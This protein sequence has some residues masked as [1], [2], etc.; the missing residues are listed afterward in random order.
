ML[1]ELVSAE[2][3]RRRRQSTRALSLRLWAAGPFAAVLVV[4]ALVTLGQWFSGTITHADLPHYGVMLLYLLGLLLVPARLVLLVSR[5]QE[6]ANGVV[7][8]TS[9]LVLWVVGGYFVLTTPA[10]KVVDWPKQIMAS[11]GETVQ[12]QLDVARAREAERQ[13]EE[14]AQQAAKAKLAD[15]ANDDLADAQKVA[16][17]VAADDAAAAAG[18]SPKDAVTMAAGLLGGGG[19]DSG[20]GGGVSAMTEQQ[21]QELGDAAVVKLTEEGV[22]L[23]RRHRG[24]MEQF[25]LA[26]GVNESWLTGKGEI[27]KQLAA[28]RSLQMVN[29]RMLE[30]LAGARD[31]LQQRLLSQGLTA[32]EIRRLS[33][34]TRLDANLASVHNICETIRDALEDNRSALVLLR[35]HWGVWRLDDQGRVK[36]S[37]DFYASQRYTTL[38]KAVDTRIHKVEGMHQQWVKT[39]SKLPGGSAATP[40]PQREG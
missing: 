23:Y 6:A 17:M 31:E 28:T 15:A 20:G 38:R 1:D 24:A 12:D 10:I 40:A 11:V 30:H 2:A 36:W 34:D 14:E 7:C 4:Y 16:S 8:G 13:A 32:E 37:Q 22:D 33:P 29:Q 18:I 19:G 39:L 21:K 5:S 9:W 25:L 3:A 26:G 35:Q 27:E